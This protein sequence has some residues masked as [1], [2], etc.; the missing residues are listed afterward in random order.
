MCVHL[1]LSLS[2]SL[3]LYIYIYVYIY[4]AY[5]GLRMACTK[6]YLVFLAFLNRGCTA[7]CSRPG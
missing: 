5:V 6:V 2:L 1:A 7:G 3:S 4:K